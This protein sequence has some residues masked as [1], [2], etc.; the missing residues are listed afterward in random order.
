MYRFGF[1]CYRSLFVH[2]RG[3]NPVAGACFTFCVCREHA[4]RG[5]ASLLSS[6]FH[7]RPVCQV[8]VLLPLLLTEFPSPLLRLRAIG[9]G[10]GVGYTKSFTSSFIFS[11]LFII[12]L[13]VYLCVYVFLHSI[14]DPVCVSGR[15]NTCQCRC[16]CLYLFVFVH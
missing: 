13:Y 16:Q 7:P 12:V 10:I 5:S 8:E 6:E 11:L 3:T 14:R 9:G 2:I 4:E 15:Y 1:H